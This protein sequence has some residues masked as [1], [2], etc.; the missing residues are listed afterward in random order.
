MPADR[1]GRRKPTA[2]EVS[3]P[4]EIL[5]VDS[6]STT[7]VPDH[8]KPYL[9]PSGTLVPEHKYFPVKRQSGGQKDTVYLLQDFAFFDWWQ[10]MVLLPE[11]DG[12]F[13]LGSRDING[14]GMICVEGHEPGFIRIEP[15]QSY[16]I[17][18]ADPDGSMYIET[19]R[20]RYCL[21][22]PSAQ[23]RSQFRKIFLPY[24]IIQTIVSSAKDQ[25]GQEYEDFLT[26]FL[27]M[28]I[29]GD[30]PEEG[31]IWDCVPRLRHAIE[32][33][34]G[35]LRVTTLVEFLLYSP[36]PQMMLRIIKPSGL[37]NMRRKAKA[38]K[39]PEVID[40]TVSD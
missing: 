23:Y 36:R 31:D 39:K 14:A 28:E 19:E 40:L 30:T 8:G 15:I 20:A 11:L 16:D 37:G 13:E 17:N 21:G 18:L 27:K 5:T 35:N 38:K 7:E 24:R 2:Y 10:D 33:L 9:P 34:E 25:P 6:N 3:F 32:N 22:V 26:K 1:K 12:H 29:V 4:D